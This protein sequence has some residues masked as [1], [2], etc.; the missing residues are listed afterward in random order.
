MN[1]KIICLAIFVGALCLASLASAQSIPNP[2]GST[3]D[4]PTLLGKIA[5][6]IGTL[7]ASLGVIMIIVAGI[8]YLTSAGS[9]ERTG[10]AKK[11]LIY[12]IVGIAVGLAAKAITD[13]ILGII[14]S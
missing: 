4:F 3:S 14:K 6:G 5:D 1:K 7:I 8:F 10:T 12:A 9:P 2:L 11:A 13:V